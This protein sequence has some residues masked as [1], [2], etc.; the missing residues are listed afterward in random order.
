MKG[1]PTC[2]VLVLPSPPVARLSVAPQES[3]RIPRD[4]G[5]EPIRAVKG[6]VGPVVVGARPT[7]KVVGECGIGIRKEQQTRQ[8]VKI[9]RTLAFLLGGASLLAVG[10]EPHMALKTVL[11]YAIISMTL[12]VLLRLSIVRRPCGFG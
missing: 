9:C 5:D 2:R 6:R 11:H 8:L 10:L 7:T 1:T 4:T 3:W 12:R